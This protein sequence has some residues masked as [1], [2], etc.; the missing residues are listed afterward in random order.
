MFKGVDTHT[1]GLIATPSQTQQL[2]RNATKTVEAKQTEFSTFKDTGCGVDRKFKA[3]TSLQGKKSVDYDQ[4]GFIS[5]I[6]SHGLVLCSI[7]M[8]QHEC[9]LFSLMLLSLLQQHLNNPK[10]VL[11]LYDVMCRAAPYLFAH[12][13]DIFV[14]YVGMLCCCDWVLY[15]AHAHMS[16]ALPVWHAMAHIPSCASRFNCASI[17]VAGDV[18]GEQ[19]VSLNH[20]LS[21]GSSP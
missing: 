17:I 20:G 8:A 13:G 4:Q 1:C 21:V 9:F 3:M 16:T 5:M 6:C 14:R 18:D 19:T 10:I 11:L 12:M 7:M 2:E 15:L